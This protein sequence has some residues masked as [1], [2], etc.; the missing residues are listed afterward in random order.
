MGNNRWAFL[1][2]ISSGTRRRP[3]VEE[4]E[5]RTLFTTGLSATGI[6]E[7]S[8]L[9]YHRYTGQVAT[10]V[11]PR[12]STWSGN[13][14]VTIN[15][16]DGSAA[17]QT[18]DIR[19]L[20]GGKFAVWGTHEFDVASSTPYKMSVQVKE[21]TG[22]L[23]TATSLF[24]IVN[25]AISLTLASGTHTHGKPIGFKIQASQTPNHKA[26][27]AYMMEYQAPGETT[28]HII[29]RGTWSGTTLSTGAFQFSGSITLPRA[30]KFLVR[31][32]ATVD[33]VQYPSHPVT[34]SVG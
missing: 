10:F 8:M 31:A 24:Q 23:A 25:P 11:D 19:S 3:G 32:L 12:L 1:G 18:T 26:P 16:G 7:V 5:Q 20:G 14:S 2:E 34:I 13:V 9:V 29:T 27:T 4:L 17:E 6:P 15:W 21:R 22:A 33:G 28:W 30:G